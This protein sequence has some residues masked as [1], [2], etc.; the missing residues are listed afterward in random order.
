MA[1]N[2]YGMLNIPPH[3]GSLPVYNWHF[4]DMTYENTTDNFTL[5]SWKREG[6][7]L[8]TLVAE[9]RLS[10]DTIQVSNIFLLFCYVTLHYLHY[11]ISSYFIFLTHLLLK[12]PRY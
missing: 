2:E 1:T 3:R 8:V 9:N 6:K 7:Y 4:G 5:H 10:N 12:V 11:V